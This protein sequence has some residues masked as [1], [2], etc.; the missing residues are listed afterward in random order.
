MTPREYTEDQLREAFRKVRTAGNWKLPIDKVIPAP[1]D[2]EWALISEAVGYYT[3]SFAD[4]QLSDDG[5]AIRVTAAG[6]YAC[7]GS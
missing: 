5:Q 1:A 2:E 7:I 6:Y 3:G 4:C